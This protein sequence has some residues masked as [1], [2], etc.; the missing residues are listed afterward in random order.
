[1]LTSLHHRPLARR[2]DP[3]ALHLLRS[4]VMVKTWSNHAF[5]VAFAGNKTMCLGASNQ[6][7]HHSRHRAVMPQQNYAKL[8]ILRSIQISMCPTTRSAVTMTLCC[9]ALDFRH[10][11]TEAVATIDIWQ[12]WKWNVSKFTDSSYITVIPNAKCYKRSTTTTAAGFIVNKPRQIRAHAEKAGSCQ[13]GLLFAHGSQRA[14][15]L[16]GHCQFFR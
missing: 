4:L 3:I 2:P 6:R 7:D 10:C 15:A 9:S 16:C 13:W 11:T 8:Q 14:E 5:R 12:E 1:M